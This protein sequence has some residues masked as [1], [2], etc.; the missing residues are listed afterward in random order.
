MST[1]GD[2]EL[3]KKVDQIIQQQ[4]DFLDKGR[5]APAKDVW[6]KSQAIGGIVVGFV[7]AIFTLLYQLNERQY[8]ETFKQAEI[9]DRRE[10]ELSNRRMQELQLMATFLPIL[11]GNDEQKKAF[12]IQLISGLGSPEL[13]STL[14]AL[15]PTPGSAVGLNNLRTSR[16]LSPTERASVDTVLRS[17]PAPLQDITGPLRIPNSDAATASTRPRGQDSTST[18]SGSC[19]IWENELGDRWCGGTCPNGATDVSCGRIRVVG[20]PSSSERRS[21]YRLWIDAY[22]T[23]WAGGPCTA[24]TVCAEIVTSERRPPASP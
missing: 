3:H 6:D 7:V 16:R 8:Q 22:G 24:E 18:G 4:Q 14:A 10:T 13:A 20:D 19:Q 1:V 9:A 15:R 21:L 23:P 17:F 11:T 2:P 5:P 12:A